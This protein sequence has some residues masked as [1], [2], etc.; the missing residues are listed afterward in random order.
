[1]RL[2]GYQPKSITTGIHLNFTD[3][4]AKQGS[5]PLNNGSL[6]VSE[7]ALF[8]FSCFQWKTFKSKTSKIIKSWRKHNTRFC[9]HSWA[10]CKESAIQRSFLNFPIWTFDVIIFFSTFSFISS[11]N[12]NTLKEMFWL[13]F[14]C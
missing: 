10:N 1:V 6:K 8:R 14:F 7:N 3:I 5:V 4:K 12:R 2:R 9:S 13:W 11:S